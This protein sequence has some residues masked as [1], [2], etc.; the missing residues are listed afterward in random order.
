MDNEVACRE[1]LLTAIAAGSSPMSTATRPLTHAGRVL[2]ALVTGGGGWLLLLPASEAGCFACIVLH[3]KAFVLAAARACRRAT[4][5]LSPDVV[6]RF[7]SDPLS[8]VFG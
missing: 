6:M 7:L 5:S 2:R 4:P 8:P 1:Q 3:R